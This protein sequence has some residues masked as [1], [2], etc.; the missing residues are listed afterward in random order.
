MAEQTVH[1][2]I[3]STLTNK[4]DFL[5]KLENALLTED[6][7]LVYRLLDNQR[8][9]I[10]A[11]GEETSVNLRD[12]MVPIEDIRVKINHILAPKFIQFLADRFPFLYYT[13]KALGQISVSFGD[14]WDSREVGHLDPSSA[15]L[16]I[17]PDVL[18]TLDRYINKQEEELTKYQSETDEL[19][20]TNKQ[21]QALLD[22]QVERDYERQELQTTLAQLERQSGF[23]KRRSKEQI[24]EINES[25]SRL[26]A[27]DKK[28]QEVP[29][30]LENNEAS[31]LAIGKEATQLD[32]E[33][34]AILGTYPNFM[35]FIES[36]HSV[37]PDYMHYLLEQQKNSTGTKTK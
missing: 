26:D 37:Y 16:V 18:G 13:E 24:D 19:I 11:L 32:Y 2:S 33:E 25:L 9:D 6:Y 8:F 30:I 4:R 7:L 20:H 27:L 36:V 15:T 34:R 35:A 29:S 23:A 10:Q 1:D 3:I 14:W 5:G 12:Q 22:A 31:M 17:R 21:L 28:A